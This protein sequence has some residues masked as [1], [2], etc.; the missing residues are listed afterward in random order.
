M[1]HQLVLYKTE[2]VNSFNYFNAIHDGVPLLLFL[3]FSTS[4]KC[5]H[6]N[7]KPLCWLTDVQ[8][9]ESVP[10]TLTVPPYYQWYQGITNISDEEENCSKHKTHIVCLALANFNFLADTKHYSFNINK[11]MKKMETTVQG[12]YLQMN[13]AL[14]VA[15]S[16]L[17]PVSNFE[18]DCSL[19][20]GRSSCFSGI[21]QKRDKMDR[22][23]LIMGQEGLN[24]VFWT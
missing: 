16:P 18:G 5:W 2:T 10:L 11:A 24:I 19:P 13:V 6:D 8:E 15:K 1:I 21:D 17:E 7:G 4:D 3:T 20:K 9:V 12:R 14:L 22:E 23:G